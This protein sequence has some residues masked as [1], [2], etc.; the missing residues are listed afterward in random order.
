[1]VD[2]NGNPI[3][4]LPIAVVPFTNIY[5]E[6]GPAFLLKDFMPESYIP[7]I[8]SQ[9]DAEGQFSVE[10][11][12]PGP[13]E[14]VAPAGHLPDDGTLPPNFDNLIADADVLSIQIGAVTLH[15]IG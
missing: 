4:E 6:M 3:P 10:G 13:I 15:L 14:F 8:K 7:L 11:I 12:R 1:M 2:V 9:T 5:G